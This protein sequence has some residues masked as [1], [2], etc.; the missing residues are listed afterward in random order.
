MYPEI[1]CNDKSSKEKKLHFLLQNTKE[2]GSS[3]KYISSC[4]FD[5]D[6]R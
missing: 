6:N 1:L 2:R 5:G 3:A 4:S